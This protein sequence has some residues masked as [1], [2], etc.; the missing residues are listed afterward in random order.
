MFP[1]SNLCH[2]GRDDLSNFGC[3]KLCLDI[4]AHHVIGLPVYPYETDHVPNRA[5]PPAVGRQTAS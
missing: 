4:D 2:S 3:A 5:S 1:T